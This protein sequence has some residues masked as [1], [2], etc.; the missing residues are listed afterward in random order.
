M[1]QVSKIIKQE[2]LDALPNRSLIR[3]TNCISDPES[4]GIVV[5]ENVVNENVVIVVDENVVIGVDENAIESGFIHNG[6]LDHLD[7]SL[8]VDENVIESSFM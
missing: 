2:M 6:N 8:V 4:T 3:I 7:I 1:D 5:D